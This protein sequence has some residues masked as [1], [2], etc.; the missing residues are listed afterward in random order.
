[1]KTPTRHDNRPKQLRR[2]L[3]LSAL[4][5][6]AGCA[7]GEAGSASLSAPDKGTNPNMTYPDAAAAPEGPMRCLDVDISTLASCCDE[8]EAH[9]VPSDLIPD[10]FRNLVGEC[11][12]GFCVPDAIIGAVDEIK[13]TECEVFR[14]PGRCLSV[15]IP[16][17]AEQAAL[18]P[19]EGCEPGQKCVPC[20]SPLDGMD[21]G[22]CGTLSCAGGEM[23]TP[24][25]TSPPPMMFSCE[26]PP[27]E[28]IID[29]STLPEC[30]PGAHCVPT[31]AVPEA[32]RGDL[33]TCNGGTGI[34]LPDPFIETGGFYAPKTCDAGGS[35]GRCLSQCVPQV[36]EQAELLGRD[37]CESDERCVPCC[38]PRTGA[39]TGV[40][41][42]ACDEPFGGTC[43]PPI[44]C[45]AGWG[46]CVNQAA[47]PAD[48]QSNLK[49][50]D[51]EGAPDLL[52]VPNEFLDDT[53]T[54]QQCTG[55]NLLSGAYEGV[56]L[57]DCLKLPLEFT[58]DSTPCPNGFVCA[59]CVGP[60]GQ[61]T[62]APGC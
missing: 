16:Q 12:A 18:L 34:C 7:G 10:G 26:N 36:S 53:W 29:P 13:L 43:Q 27:T 25:S 1:M 55:Q 15:C 3:L 47:V 17:V 31:D 42:R 49:K 6:A 11:E 20:I 9:C 23:N 28:P 19:E 45:C 56:C 54:P 38:D 32:Q 46:T 24:N 48:L 14:Q 8:D 58:L 39:E 50:C 22:V 61:P 30:C 2:S 33:G 41:G 57:P 52:C 21:T 59:P 40:C 60:L 35:E 44:T 62:G 4:L 37:I 5:L 51:A